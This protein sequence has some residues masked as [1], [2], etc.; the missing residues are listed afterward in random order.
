MATPMITKPSATLANSKKIDTNIH[1]II[2]RPHKF[3]RVLM[4]KLR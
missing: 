1:R 3:S 4:A 2:K